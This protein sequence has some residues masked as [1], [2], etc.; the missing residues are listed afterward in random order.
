MTQLTTV[1]IDLDVHRKI[2]AARQ[3]FTETPNTVLR[4]L[5]G[6]DQGQ[7][8]SDSSHRSWTGKGV[9]LPHGTELKMTYNG[10]EHVGEI[11]DGLWVVEGTESNNPSSAASLAAKTKAGNKTGL[12]G[13]HYWHV[14]RPSDAKW[15]RLNKLRNLA[16]A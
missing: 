2:E 10:I 3:S 16:T 12:N 8:K 6:V 13:W 15:T 9:S 11:N 7:T 5:L 14:K 1:E 4:R